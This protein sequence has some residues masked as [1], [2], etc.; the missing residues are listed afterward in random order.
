MLCT[1][2]QPVSW[3]IAS[4]ESHYGRHP[5]DLGQY[6]VNPADGALSG[7]RL[8]TR[9]ALMQGQAEMLCEAP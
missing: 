5:V 1:V 2:I 6:G 8:A 7:V 4:A 9:M 3:P